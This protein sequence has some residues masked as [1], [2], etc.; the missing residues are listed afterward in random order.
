MHCRRLRLDFDFGKVIS[1]GSTVLEVNR[2][3]DRRLQLL[4]SQR[5]KVDGSKSMAA[6]F[7]GAIPSLFRGLRPTA[8]SRA[9]IVQS[10]Q[11][12]V[13]IRWNDERDPARPDPLPGW[14]GPSV[15]RYD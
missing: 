5:K 12:V 6:L 15:L 10:G 9:A 13:R 7:D 2:R 1:P 4:N 8:Q 3:T 14:N 11:P